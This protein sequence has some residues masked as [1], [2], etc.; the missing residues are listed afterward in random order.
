[1]PKGL[2]MEGLE[3]AKAH[4]IRNILALR[5]DP[6]AGQE[7]KANPDGFTCALDLI[8]FIKEKYGDHFSISTAGYPEGHPGKLDDEGKITPEDYK[9]EIEY[10]KAK[11]DAGA[12]I[13]I[14]QLFYDADIF[15]KFVKDCRAAGITVPILPGLLPVTRYA[16]L[17][18]MVNLCKTYM[19][20][21]MK[22]KVEEVKDD[23]E[24]IK[25]YGVSQCVEMINKIRAAD[26]GVNHFHFYTINDCAQSF[27]VLQELGVYNE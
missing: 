25:A 10:L 3:F 27:R 7:F 5:G 20:P 6:P 21:E 23:D 4:D 9:K 16:S 11:V 19:P 15:I 13:I 2:I 14:T 22:K 26:I 8:K 12:R 1:M 24:A 17:Q 18:R